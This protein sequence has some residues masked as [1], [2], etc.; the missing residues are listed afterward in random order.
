[1][2]VADEPKLNKRIP[3][4]TL[5]LIK[6]AGHLPQEEQPEAFVAAFANNFTRLLG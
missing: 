2:P 4:S 3:N 1:V 6:Q 5:V